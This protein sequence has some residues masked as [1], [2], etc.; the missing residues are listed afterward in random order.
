MGGGLKHSPDV[1][2]A[3]PVS[4]IAARDPIRAVADAGGGD[5]RQATEFCDRTHSILAMLDTN[6]AS[7]RVGTPVRLIEA[8]GELHVLTDLGTLGRV[9]GPAERALRACL[10]IGFDL[11]GEVEDSNA[12]ARTV[13]LKVVGRRTEAA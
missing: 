1:R 13:R 4:L 11:P 10:Q 6:A 2:K 9:S 3:R 8:N 12:A 7:P 5:L